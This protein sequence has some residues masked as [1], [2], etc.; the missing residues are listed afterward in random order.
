[1]MEAH[2]TV[3][4]QQK[5]KKAMKLGFCEVKQIHRIKVC[6]C[7]CDFFLTFLCCD[8]ALNFYFYFHFYF[9]PLLQILFL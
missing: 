1:M 6:V 8:L 4:A 2:T 5:R 3:A 9:Q 7:L